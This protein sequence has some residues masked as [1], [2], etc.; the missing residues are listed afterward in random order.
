M[1]VARDKL[2]GKHGPNHVTF[3]SLTYYMTL[4]H[5]EVLVVAFPIGIMYRKI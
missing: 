3:I 2:K 5:F 1:L 4:D